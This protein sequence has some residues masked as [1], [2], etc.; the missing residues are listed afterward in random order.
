MMDVL[1]WLLGVYAALSLLYFAYAGVMSFK[2]ALDS[3]AL[4]KWIIGVVGVWVLMAWLLD[5]LIN[6]TLL[7]LVFWEWP[8]EATVSK[9]L[10]RLEQGTGWRASLAH[11]VC[12]LLDPLDPSGE[13]CKP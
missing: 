4:P 7:C 9:R 12:N 6:W 1:F 3:A 11:K 2:R 13:H 10:A 8:R 5:V